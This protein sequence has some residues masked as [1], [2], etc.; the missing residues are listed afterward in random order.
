M[1][2]LTGYL[3]QLINVPPI[4]FRFQFNPE[5]LQEKRSYKYEGSNEFGK[6]D[7]SRTGAASGVLGTALGL[8]DDLKGAGPVLTG[9]NG[10]KK[11]AD[12]DPRELEIEFKLDA[13]VPGPMD[14]ALDDPSASHY[15]G[16][17]EPDLAMLRSFV[18]PAWDP[19]DLV[20]ALMQ[21]QF[22]CP[23]APPELKFIYAGLSIDCVMTELNIKHT[24]FQ[25]DGKPM[26][27]EVSVKL[28][29]QSYSV[30]PIIEYGLRSGYV[31]RG[32]FR[33]G[34]GMDVVRVTPGL[35]GIVS[36][37]E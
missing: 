35:G 17:I 5:M 34:G 26:R 13:T 28:K 27:A 4:I 37:F 10:M 23:G 1:T 19:V 11:T 6:W 16:S 18:N 3:A 7:F 36:L 32:A 29:E 24:E 21:K 31:V 8:Y 2:R 22:P 25:D 14:G 20:K 33:H 15:D 9:A 12:Q 30:S